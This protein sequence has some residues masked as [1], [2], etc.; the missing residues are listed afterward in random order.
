MLHFFVAQDMTMASPVDPAGHHRASFRVEDVSQLCPY[1]W[2]CRVVLEGQCQDRG[3][4]GPFGS[5]ERM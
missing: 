4:H 2:R 3:G 5:T 1:L